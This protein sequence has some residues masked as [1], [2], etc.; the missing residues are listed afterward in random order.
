MKKNLK[1]TF[2]CLLL[3]FQLSSCSNL[4][5]DKEKFNKLIGRSPAA[6]YTIDVYR[7]EKQKLIKLSLLSTIIWLKP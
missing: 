3:A 6:S 7:K 2:L 4:S 5:F 1:W